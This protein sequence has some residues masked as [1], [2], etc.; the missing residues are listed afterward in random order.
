MKAC[1]EFLLDCLTYFKLA[2]YFLPLF[3]VSMPIINLYVY[4]AIIR[5]IMHKAANLKIN[6]VFFLPGAVVVCLN[7]HWSSQFFPEGIVSFTASTCLH[8]GGFVFWAALQVVTA[9]CNKALT[10]LDV[11]QY[12]HILEGH[13]LLKLSHQTMECVQLNGVFC[14][15]FM[16]CKS[17]S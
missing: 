8:D 3:W 1:D 4:Y 17:N 14:K 9:C 10:V 16:M 6:P 12:C 15:G 7:L 5:I 2:Q 11:W 13:L